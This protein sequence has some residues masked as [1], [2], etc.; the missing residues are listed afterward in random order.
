MLVYSTPY[1]SFMS[2]WAFGSLPRCGGPRKSPPP[3]H[4][5]SSSREKSDSIADV[6]LVF[7]KRKPSLTTRWEEEK[8]KSVLS[9]KRFGEKSGDSDIK[10]RSPGDTA[11]GAPLKS[12]NNKSQFGHEPS[13]RQSSIGRK[14][15]RQTRAIIYPTRGSVRNHDNFWFP[16]QNRLS[17]KLFLVQQPVDM[18]LGKIRGKKLSEKCKNDR[19]FRNCAPTCFTSNDVPSV[20]I[21]VL[22]FPFTNPR[23]WDF[24]WFL[25]RC[26][27][28]SPVMLLSW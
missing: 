13:S 21:M 17:T 3:P 27:Y 15:K 23:I 24:S 18:W 19:I 9:R 26:Y 7:E 28:F 8:E 10:L 12:N 6:V 4:P 20:L 16:P 14:R 22:F 1:F 2:C 5:P 25:C 11:A